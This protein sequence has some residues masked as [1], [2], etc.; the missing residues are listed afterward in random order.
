[1]VQGLLK[2]FA[3]DVSLVLDTLNESQREAVAAPAG[4]IM[5]LAG[6]GSG[7]TRVLVHRIAWYIQTKQSSP[8]G[9]LAVTFTNKAAA[10]MRSRIETLLDAPAG[11]MWVGTFHGLTH[12]ILRAHWQEAG[13]PQN[14]TILDS[15]DQY[16]T[17]RRLLRSMEIDESNCPPREVQWFINARKDDGLRP[18]HIDDHGDHTL[19]QM[20]RIYQAYEDV[21]NRSGVVDFAEL[22]LRAHELFRDNKSILDQYRDRFRFVLVDEFQDTN[23]LQYAWLRLLVGDKGSLFAVGDDDQCLDRGTMVT[24]GD[25]SY[26]PI[27]KIS[28]DDQVLS[29]FGAGDFRPARVT[30]CFKRQRKG[31]M[32]KLYLRSGKIIK[33]TPEHT[34]FAGYCLGE[35]PQTYFLYM[36]YK[37]GVG[38]R[39]GTSQ[40]YTKGRAKPQLGFKQRSIQEHADAL[41]II[42]THASENEARA[43]ETITSLKYG[44]PTL[45]F[46]ARKGKA[47]NG[48]VHDVNYISRVF[49]SLD[50]E[51]SGQRLLEDVGLDLNRPHHMPQARNSN[52]RSVVITLCGD[53]RGSNPMHRISMVGVNE[54]DK[55]TLQSL[56]LS[57]RQAKKGSK[58]WRFETVRSDFGEVM[59]IANRI[60]KALDTKMVLNG[61]MLKVSLPFINA[62]SI[63]QGMVMASSDGSFDVIEKIK[64]EK[65]DTFVYD[66]NVDRTHNFVA[67][68]VVTHNS[69]YSWRGA[70]VENMQQFKKDFSDPLL[71]KLEQNYRSTANILNAANALITNNSSRLG[72]ELWTDGDSG[73]KIAIYNGYNEHDEARYV[74]EQISSWQAKTGHYNDSAVLYRVSA[75]SRVIEEGLMRASIPYRVYGGMRFY[76]RAEIKDALA[77]VRL[78]TF[79]D[80]DVSFE[81]IVNTPTRGIGQRTVEELRSISRQEKCSL[82]QAAQNIL[83]DK[84]LSARALNALEG[85]M[86]LITHMGHNKGLPLDEIVDNVIKASGLIDHYR[87]EK[88]ERG[89]ARIEN[90]EELVNAAGEFNTDEDEMLQDMEPLQAFLAHAA[91]ESGETQAGEHTDCVNLMTLHSA[92]G[93]EFPNVYLIGMEEGLFPHQRSMEDLSQLEEERRLCYVGITRAEKALTMVYTQHRRLHG[94]DYYPQP[95]RFISELPEELVNEV[96]MGGSIAEPMFARTR[97]GGVVSEGYDTSSGVY[98]LGQRVSHAKFGEGIILNLEGSGGTTRVQVNF[99]EAGSKWLVAEYANLETA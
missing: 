27:H 10:E 90:M 22:L 93:L 42:R 82:W 5:V 91:L 52:R 70:R 83:T 66:I 98:T 80:D 19:H 50:T 18:Q 81:R 12:R 41:W 68:G 60:R 56:G 67:N 34:H 4:N 58:S 23:S 21:C 44:L 17:I 9:I 75:Q 95:S 13:L 65:A 92:K 46:T 71:V 54:H 55:H 57:V 31:M 96:R 8:F 69:I 88:G 47:R 45:P 30:D 6:A 94:Q 76:E 85:F 39:L 36:M 99:E 37:A 51:T 38:Y 35:T 14:F 49:Q 74:V 1:M 11:G 16:R 26:K 63:R 25:G 53:R 59:D 64:Y 86:Q 29:S 7:K 77:Y 32:V 3:M 84:L 28:V 87:K 43:D 78:S 20:I 97:Q 40:V 2:S 73:E 61:H 48:L 79:Q 33:S 15:D 24:M 72:K 62:L 89:L